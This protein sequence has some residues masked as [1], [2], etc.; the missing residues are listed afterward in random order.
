MCSEDLAGRLSHA[1]LGITAEFLKDAE[2][3]GLIDRRRAIAKHMNNR[4]ANVR[5]GVVGHLQEPVPNQ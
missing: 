1:L 2:Y 5:I 4:A 3:A